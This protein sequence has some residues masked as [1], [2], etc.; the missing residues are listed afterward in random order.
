MGRFFVAG[1]VLA[2][3]AHGFLEGMHW[4]MLPAYAALVV[5]C[6]FGWKSSPRRQWPRIV[7]AWSALALTAASVVLSFVLP[8][9]RLPKPTGPYPVGTTILYLT[10]TSRIEDAAPV[11]GLPREIA[12]QLWY[13]A[14]PSSNRFAPYREPRETNLFSSYE[15]VI[16]TNSRLD[17]PVADA[18][19]PFPVILF[20]HGWGGRRTYDTFLTEELASH[21]YFVASIDHTYNARQVAFPDGTGCAHQRGR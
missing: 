2:V 7:A 21:G 16:H 11:A 9:F 14:G 8:M 4:Q 3:V 19:A 6:L 5:L 20:N 12:V 15:S 17:A 13:P 18:T 10:D 1:A